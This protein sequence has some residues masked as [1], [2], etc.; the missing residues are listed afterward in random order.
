VSIPFHCQSNSLQKRFRFHER[1]ADA[2]PVTDPVTDN[3]LDNGI[4]KSDSSAAAA[5]DADSD[6]SHA[7]PY[8]D[9]FEQAAP[10]SSNHLV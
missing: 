7:S 4:E 2:E 9:M 8:E 6:P 3:G 10:V 5:V 1:S